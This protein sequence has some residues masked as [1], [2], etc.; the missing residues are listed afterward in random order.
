[1]FTIDETTF[2]KIK[3]LKKLVDVVINIE[4][5]ATAF[6]ETSEKIK[7]LI[8]NIN[9]P[10][11]YK[12]WCVCLDIFDYDLKSSREKQGVY[13]RKWAVFF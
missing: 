1:M 4:C 2:T 5:S 6:K 9:N 7:Y 12:S 13:W 3:E 10:K 11:I 8:D